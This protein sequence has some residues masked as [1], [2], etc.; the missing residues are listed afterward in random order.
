MSPYTNCSRSAVHFGE[1]SGSCLS[2]FLDGLLDWRTENLE[3]HIDEEAVSE[4][5]GGGLSRELVL[6]RGRKQKH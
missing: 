2:T 4:L 3:Q 1:T 6:S 5:H